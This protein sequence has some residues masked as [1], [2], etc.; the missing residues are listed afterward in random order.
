MLASSSMQ[1]TALK[2]ASAPVG[3]SLM[4]YTDS[5]NDRAYLVSNNLTGLPGDKEYEAWLVTDD[6][7]VLKAGMLGA[8]GNESP[9]VHDL[10]VQ[11]PVNRFKLVVITVEK[12]GGVEKSEQ[13]PVLIGTIKG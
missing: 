7:R 10:I 13:Q 3:G 5:A 12:K 4:L 2:P 6:N 11:E 9:S 1:V 8:G